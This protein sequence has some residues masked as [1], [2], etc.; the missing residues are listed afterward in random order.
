MDLSWSM[1]LSWILAGGGILGISGVPGLALSWRSPWSQR[2][3]TASN[4]AGSALGLAGAVRVF[5][6]G[7]C[8]SFLHSWPI[9]GAACAMSVDALGGFFLIPVFLM[10]AAGSVYG[11][12]YW[13]QREHPSNG[14]RLRFFWGTVMAGMVVLI[15]ARNAILFLLGWEFMALSGFF[16]VGTEDHV[17]G[18]RKASW[19]Y[20]ISTHV[21][22]LTLFGMFV[23][24]RVVT[25]SFQLRP[26]GVHET[27]LVTLYWIFFMALVAFGVKAGLMPLHVWLPDAHASAPSHVSALLSGIMLK[28]G[29]YGM[30]RIF[31]YLPA[32][33]I[34][35]GAVLL[36]LGALSAVLGI[37]FAIGQRDLKRL[38]AYSSV[39]NIGIIVMGLGLAMVGRST[40]RA[41]WVLLGLGGS[42]LHVWNHSLFKPLLFMGAGSVVHAMH[43]REIEQMGGLARRMPGTSFLFLVGAV[44]I[45]GLPPLNGFVSE[46]IIYLG[47]FRTLPAQGTPAWTVG[48]LAAPALALVGALAVA[49]FVMVSGAVFL[50]SPRSDRAQAAHESPALMLGPMALL[51]TCCLAIGLGSGWL[52]PLMDR[53]VGC[54]VPDLSLR[55]TTL[56]SLV[57]FGQVSGTGIAL[58][59]GAAVGYLGSELWMRPGRAPKAGTWDCG[60]ARPTARMQYTSSSFADMLVRLLGG[61][62]RPKT[63]PPKLGGLFPASTGFRSVVE[64]VVL[65]GFILPTI[66]LLRR[67]AERT[68][69]LQRGQTQPYVLYILATVV[70][71]LLWTLPVGHLF[72]R[73]LTR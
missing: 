32:P 2:I 8:N 70:I 13:R 37:A 61:V 55:G 62:L 69:V 63:E 11:S 1:P 41:D 38:L 4:L 19:I 21:A 40:G 9:P 53:A 66:G 20:F 16:L 18:V 12:G 59:V 23:L 15:L 73:L 49:C 39:E 35:W 45:A 64:D 46:L 42:L 65:S 26:I 67:W 24:L 17:A 56:G 10:S 48:A 27:G 33:P 31:G 57:P 54:W 5:A 29:V 28:M 51:G 71:L 36:I 25:G 30:I 6:F 34:S 58:L 14:R 47:L 60:Y 68:H 44:A 3:A 7:E 52:A 43:S 50:G 22:T 72:V